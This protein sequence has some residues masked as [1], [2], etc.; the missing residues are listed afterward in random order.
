MIQLQVLNKILQDNDSSFLINNNLDREYFSDYADE[1]DFVKSHVEQYGKVPDQVTFLTAFP[2]FDIIEVNENSRYLLEQLVEDKNKRMLAVIFNKIRKLLNEGKTEEAML[3]YTTSSDQVV[4]AKPFES[5]DLLHDTSRY[6]AYVDRCY[7]FSKYYISTGFTELDRVIGGWDRLEE[8]ATVAA[9]PGVGK[10]WIMLKFA[11]A[12]LEQGLTVGVYSGEMSARKVGYRFDTLAGHISNYGITKG[13]AAIQTDYKRY[14]D[15]LKDKYK[16]AF[17]VLTPDSINGPAGIT[18]LRAFIEKDNLDIL[19]VD[20][21]SLLE[22]DRKAR[23]P[24]DRAANISKDLKNLQVMKRIPIIAVSQQKRTPP[25]EIADTSHVAQS[26]RISQDST[27]LIFLEHK[28]DILTLS[29][30]KSRDSETDS[31]LR[32]AASFDKGIFT[33]IPEEGNA[34]EGQG[35]EELQKEFEGNVF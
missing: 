9:R 27:V 13:N 6:D 29:L 3:L 8:L 1:F 35:S 21:H 31:K 7:D 26:D 34:L 4:K 12:A 16:G 24:V 2:Q 32:Y 22:D 20:Q 30:A 11:V 33:Y 5:V 14:I 10:T 28:D 23:N 18:A 17:K 15:S 19:F 25:E